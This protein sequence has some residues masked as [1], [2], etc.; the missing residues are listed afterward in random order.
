MFIG[1]EKEAAELERLYETAAFQM[2]IMYGR[3]RVGKTTLIS[4]FTEGKRT[5]Y[6]TA[7]ES[8]SARNLEL[9]SK[10]VLKT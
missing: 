4:R 1:R 9:F 6:F 2:L 8:D 5:V 10:A 3:R 7:I